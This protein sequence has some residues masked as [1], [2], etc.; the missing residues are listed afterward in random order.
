MRVAD[1]YY[2]VK[3]LESLMSNMFRV[4]IQDDVIF[5]EKTNE[6]SKK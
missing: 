6:D 3:A 1:R 5:A 2:E 4:M